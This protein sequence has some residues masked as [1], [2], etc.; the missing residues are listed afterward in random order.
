MT[1]SETMR[2]AIR[3]DGRTLSALAIAAGLDRGQVVR[4][5]NAD[6]ELTLPGADKLCK[7]LGLEL[8]PVH[9]ARSARPA[10][11]AD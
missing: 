11:T 10:S 4:F 1:L 3:R 6:R 9:R 8:R 5:F 7:A 2:H